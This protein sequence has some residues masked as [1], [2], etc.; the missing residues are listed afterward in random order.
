[1][2]CQVGNRWP[3]F[4]GRRSLRVEVG[5]QWQ[6]PSPACRPH[7]LPPR[8]VTLTV[9]SVKLEV[10]NGIVLGKIQPPRPKVAPAGDTYESIFP[11]YRE[12]EVAIRKVPGQYQV[13][14]PLP[15]CHLGW[16]HLLSAA[17]E[18][19]RRV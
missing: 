14:A 16:R 15:S 9:G 12:Y 18:L 3:V 2:F 7:D 1:M 5:G 19:V 6:G 17:G 8:A 10:L 11:R 13:R 4:H